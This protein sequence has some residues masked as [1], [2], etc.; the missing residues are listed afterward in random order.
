M[1]NF[2]KE[3]IFLVTGASSGIGKATALLLNALN[4]TVIAVARREEELIALKKQAKYPENII[5]EKKDLIENIE[6]LPQYVKEL[7]E[8]YGKFS[9][10]AYCAGISKIMPL[11]GLDYASLEESLKINYLAPIFMAK[12]LVNKTNNVGK[13]T[14][15]VFL[16]SASAKSCEQGMLSYSGAKAALVAAAKVLSRE[17]S[18]NGIRVNTLS[19]MAI[20]TEMLDEM[21]RDYAIANY[22]LGIG[23][24]EDVANSIIYLLSS[25][26]KWITGQDYILDGGYL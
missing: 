4:A 15:L 13:N 12:G 2:S 23:Q 18:K 24:V 8:K 26:A 16:A 3:Q 9:G 19:P 21:A 17:V 14:S 5:I 22:P 6:A 25:Q 10:M 11:K 1:I 20:D 7:R